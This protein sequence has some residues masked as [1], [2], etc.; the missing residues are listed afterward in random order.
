M[1][2]SDVIIITDVASY[3]VHEGLF[4]ME[5]SKDV[6]E[7]ERPYSCWFTRRIQ[8]TTSLCNKQAM[9]RM[10]S[11]ATKFRRK[12]R[13]DLVLR[14]L[15]A[16]G[17]G[18]RAHPL[19]GVAHTQGS[20]SSLHLPSLGFAGFRAYAFLLARAINGMAPIIYSCNSCT[21]FLIHRRIPPKPVDCNRACLGTAV[22]APSG[23]N[24]YEGLNILYYTTKLTH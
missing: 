13:P 19:V 21:P 23:L 4:Q 5:E 16:R 1:R 12:H 14:R 15:H 24:S 2:V 20:Q 18:S 8:E 7:T 9:W 6:S 11:E 3:L 17:H 22:R 10:N